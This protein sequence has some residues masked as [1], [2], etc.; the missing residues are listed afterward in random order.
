MKRRLSILTLIVGLSIGGLLFGAHTLLAS[1]GGII[2]YSG[3]PSNGGQNCNICHGG[4]LEPDVVIYGPGIA[5]PGELLT[6][7]LR[8]SG[9]Q[10]ISGGFN[11]STN[12]GTLGV[13]S[14]TTDVREAAG[15]LTHSEPKSV[16]ADG[17]VDFEF[18]WTAPITE[19]TAVLYAAGNSTNN[20][21]QTAGDAAKAITRNIYIG[22]FPEKVYLPYIQR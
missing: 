2:G 16:D 14:G 3:N 9:G 13:I 4:G 8:I 12:E 15:Q 21:N 7:T 19:G 1:P 22:T 17:N 18:T 11:V 6:L 5:A 10:E 20:A